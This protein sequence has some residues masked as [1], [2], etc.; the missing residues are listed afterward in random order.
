M[1]VED[2]KMGKFYET[3]LGTAKAIAVGGM[4][5]PSIKMEVQGEG[6]LYLSPRDVTA[7]TVEASAQE[8]VPLC[9]CSVLY[10]NPGRVG[11]PVCVG[12]EIVTDEDPERDERL[13]RHAS[14][15][16]FNAH[17]LLEVIERTA[18]WIKDLAKLQAEGFD[19][20]QTVKDD[21]YLH[22]EKKG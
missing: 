4:N 8:E 15:A 22:L 14:V 9:R 10:P 6:M 2:I 1:N 18:D 5:P 16:W 19:L 17:T 3:T 12:P 21:G 7:E 13:T 20:S 11:C